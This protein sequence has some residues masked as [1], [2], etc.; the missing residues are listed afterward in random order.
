M[1]LPPPAVA[2]LRSISFQTHVTM[3][4][5][6]DQLVWEL[7]KGHNAFVNKNLHNRWFSKEANNI[8]G[9]HNYKFSGIAN[10]KAVNV[11]PADN[12]VVLSKTKPTKGKGKP[13]KAN[14]SV[15][16]KKDVRRMQK[17]IAK[18]IDAFRPDLK[19]ASLAKLSAVHKSLR[20]IKAG[21]KK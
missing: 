2:L 3:A 6:S 18:E 21:P 8:T 17:S 15:T 19:K 9:E 7:V 10:S 5:Y 12:A 20:V 1:G 14:Y 13:A 16:M 4:L 11:S